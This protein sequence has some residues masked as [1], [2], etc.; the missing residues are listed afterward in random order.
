MTI[1][2]LPLA[3]LVEDFDLYP[4]QAVSSENVSDILGAI[5]AGLPIPAPIVDRESKRIVDGF[6][7]CRAWRRELGEDGVI[8]VDLRD[9]SSEV[10]LFRAAVEF[11][12]S[13]GRKLEAIERR[14]IALRLRDMGDGDTEIARILHI[15]P[16]RVE[17][18][19]LRTATVTEENGSIRLEPLKRPFFHLSGT[20]LTEGQSQAI[21]TAPGTSYSLLIRQLRSAMQ[22]RFIDRTDENLINSLQELAYDILAYLESP[23][24][25]VG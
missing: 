25:D 24:S 6:H 12:I 5:K 1:M 7:R 17:K 16:A 8:D 3:Q 23:V 14:K 2:Q 9:Y 10:E 11:N 20:E 19:F 21:R 13:H 4:R 15:P 22:N 18:I